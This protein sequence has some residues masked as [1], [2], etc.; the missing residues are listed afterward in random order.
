MLIEICVLLQSPSFLWLKGPVCHLAE[1]GVCH[2]TVQS[3]VHHAH[4]SNI[5]LMRYR[6]KSI[7]VPQMSCPSRRV[8]TDFVFARHFVVP[9]SW[10]D[11]TVL[12]LFHV[13]SWATAFLLSIFISLSMMASCQNRDACDGEKPISNS[14]NPPCCR[15]YLDRLIHAGSPAILY[16]IPL[17]R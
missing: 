9:T 6:P 8:P 4:R 7:N 11:H 5:E 17:S 16:T 12:P 10:R 15:V 1:L 3:V 2:W 14:F 13:F